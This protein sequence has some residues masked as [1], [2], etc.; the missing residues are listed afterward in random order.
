MNRK[1]YNS[2]PKNVRQAIDEISGDA[3]VAKIRRLVE[4]V[5]KPPARPMRSNAATRSSR[6]T[7]PRA[8]NGKTRF[9]R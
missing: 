4:Q 1:K 5:G 7:T 6:S 3:L 9:G 8:R 2:L